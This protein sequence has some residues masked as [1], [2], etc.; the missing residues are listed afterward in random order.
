MVLSLYR[1]VF[2]HG[3]HL[4][5]LTP[6]SVR[7]KQQYPRQFSKFIRDMGVGNRA[8]LLQKVDFLYIGWIVGAGYLEQS[9]KEAIENIRRGPTPYY[10][11]SASKPNIPRELVQTDSIN[12]MRYHANNHNNFYIY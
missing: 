11:G 2:V 6:T 9:S 5:E 7:T 10:Y 4:P 12:R 3:P 1:L 8:W